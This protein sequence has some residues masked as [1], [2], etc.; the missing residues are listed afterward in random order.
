MYNTQLKDYVKIYKGFYDQDFCKRIVFELS[1]ANWIKHQFYNPLDNSFVHGN[2]ELS[3]SHD[4]VPSKKEL[5][6]NIWNVLEQYILKDMGY[7]KDW[8]NMWNGYSFSRFNKYDESTEMSL[9]CDHI[10]SLFDGA[11]KGIPVITV[12]GALNEDYEGGEFI[13]CNEQINL[14]TGD[15]IVFPS[16]FLYPHQVKP[17]KSGTRYSFVSW[18]W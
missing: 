15:V 14:K 18:A 4:Q 13:L 1:N 11:R 9:H 5:D 16:N 17:I 2:N 8:Y 3:V 10:H 7:M 12:L 6:K